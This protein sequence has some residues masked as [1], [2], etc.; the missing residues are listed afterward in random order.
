MTSP[1]ADPQQIQGN[2][3]RPFGGRHQAF[4]ALSFRNGRTAARRWLAAVASRVTGTDDVPPRGAALVRKQDA[5]TP[6]LG[7]QC[8]GGTGHVVVGAHRDQHGTGDAAHVRL[9]HRLAR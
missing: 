7:W 8:F 3:L 4:V 1:L 6:G 2:I 9:G 5:K